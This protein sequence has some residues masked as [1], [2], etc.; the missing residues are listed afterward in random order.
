MCLCVQTLYSD[1]KQYEREYN[2]RK[3]MLL[4]HTVLIFNKDMLVDE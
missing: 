3:Y 1:P 4:F 2:V